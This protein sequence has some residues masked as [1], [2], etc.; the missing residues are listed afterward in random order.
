MNPTL[1]KLLALIGIWTPAI[2]LA[3]TV[4]DCIHPLC[5]VTAVAGV[6]LI[7]IV[8]HIVVGCLYMIYFKPVDYTLKDE[9]DD[10]E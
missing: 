2:W 3:T 9:E 8:G 4:K 10:G 6:A 5:Q 1:F 7:L